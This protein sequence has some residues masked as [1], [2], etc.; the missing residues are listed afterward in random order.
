MFS[1]LLSHYVIVCAA[2]IVPT[3][4]VAFGQGAIC[5]LALSVLD[6]QPESR[7]PLNRLVVIALAISE[8][9]AILSLLISVFLLWGNTPPNLATLLGELG[10]IGA[11]GIPAA[12]IG[13]AA[14]LPI[15]AAL[16]ALQR[17]PLNAPNISNLL[18]LAVSIGQTPVIFGFFLAWII[19]GRVPT[20]DCMTTG[21]QLLSCGIAFGLGTIGPSIGI[22]LFGK[23]A[24][25]SIG[26]NRE[27]YASIFSFT[28]ISQALIE[29]PILFSFVVALLILLRPL[30]T[31]H[32]LSAVIYLAT[33]FSV[34]IP[35]FGAGISS[36][37]IARTAC[38]EI[39]QNP[40]IY[41]MLSRLSIFGQTLTDTNAIYGLIVALLMFYGTLP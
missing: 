4:A 1:L 19:L 5:R 24:C 41:Q 15:R 37:R 10:I 29:T 11:L 20:V 8:T 25:T 28:V 16:D 36:G 38:R 27:A 40:P 12:V 30:P 9:S 7:G 13:F 22:A 23:Q 2:I 18:L 33:A 26:Q 34:S 14:S 3:F 6:Q 17:Q 21:I 39:A 32:A 35:T 31:T